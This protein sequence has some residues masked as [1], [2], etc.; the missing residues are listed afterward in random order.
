[1][2]IKWRQKLMLQNNCGGA[3]TLTIGTIVT[4]VV[5]AM[6]IFFVIRN[7]QK[8]E[9][10]RR[11][12]A[13]QIS[14]YGLIQALEKIQQQPSWRDGFTKTAYLDGAYRVKVN[15]RDSSGTSILKVESIG[16]CGSAR[17]VHVSILHLSV[18]DGDSI[19][20]QKRILQK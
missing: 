13:V 2:L 18:A 5:V 14:E 19:W 7:A 4:L 1:M 8:N 6:L 12:K 15:Q 17:K 16:V 10:I 20:V 9:P 3:A 11:R